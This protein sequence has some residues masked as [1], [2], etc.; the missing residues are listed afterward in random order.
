MIF[1]GYRLWNGQ[2]LKISACQQKEIDLL[3]N[4]L[5]VERR[6]R[7]AAEQKLQ[8]IETQRALNNQ[9]GHSQLGGSPL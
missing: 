2:W 6:R 1:L 8:A 4:D 3:K 9:Y 7:L 5:T